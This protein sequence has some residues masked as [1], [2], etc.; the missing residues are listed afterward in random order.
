MSNLTHGGRL[1]RPQK[2]KSLPHRIE[3][4]RRN[5]QGFDRSAARHGQSSQLLKAT[6]RRP[7]IT[8][9]FS[10]RP[11]KVIRMLHQDFGRD[12]SAL[13]TTSLRH[14]DNHWTD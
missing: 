12:I 7:K 10:Q 9:G 3:P 5:C 13:S 1:G 8:L 2:L 4:L 11:F 6:F 14:V